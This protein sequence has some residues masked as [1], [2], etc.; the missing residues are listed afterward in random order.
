MPDDLMCE[1]IRYAIAHEVG[2]TMGLM[3]NMGASY[4]F[5][6][7]SLRDPRFTQQVRHY[8]EHHG[9]CAQQL[10]RSAGRQ[11]DAA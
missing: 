10:H 9:L 8:A 4:A 1:S 5:P 2:H 3:H 6:V 7:D 11:G